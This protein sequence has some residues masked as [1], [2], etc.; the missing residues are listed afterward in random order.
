MKKIIVLL[1]VSLLVLAAQA[2]QA[3]FNDG[4]SELYYS[5]N[6]EYHVSPVKVT[7]LLQYESIIGNGTPCVVFFT[8]TWCGPCKIVNTQVE[9][10]ANEHK[11]IIFLIVDVDDVPAIPTRYDIKE[12]P[13]LLFLNTTGNVC[14]RIIGVG[15][16]QTY[17]ECIM[18][19]SN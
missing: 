1:F 6:T 16:M 13:T 5:S 12:V 15:S 11:N 17:E 9:K 7:S 18:K 3:R 14:G 19:I 4:F 8:A 2:S 10:L